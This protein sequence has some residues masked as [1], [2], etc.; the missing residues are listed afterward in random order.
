M[1]KALMSLF[2]CKMTN[3]I[4]ESVIN[5]VDGIK[6][7]IQNLPPIV[8]Q[9]T[10]NE[11]VL[12]LS[13]IAIKFKDKFLK[14]DL[15]IYE[16][17]LVELPNL[18]DESYENNPM[19]V[20]NILDEYSKLYQDTKVQTV[21]AFGSN[22]DSIKSTYDLWKGKYPQIKD[23]I[24]ENQEK[25]LYK[26]FETI[27]FNNNDALNILSYA[28]F[29]STLYDW[30]SKRQ[31]EFKNTLESMI[32]KVYSYNDDDVSKKDFDNI[33]NN[34]EISLLGK[35]LYSNLVETLNEYGSSLSNE[36]KA[37]IIKNILND[38]IN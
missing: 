3:S 29:N 38:L 7:T 21:N 26:A 32:N 10:K 36:E 33:D 16:T 31:L 1:I 17:L 12:A 35:T 9:T 14:Y 23:V 4:N 27:K 6:N 5:L 20:K 18:L 28:L 11:N 30:N 22:M 34:G 25:M 2:D 37:I 24:L 8:V 15:N 13:E 19:K